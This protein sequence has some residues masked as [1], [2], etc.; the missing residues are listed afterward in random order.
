[1]TLLTGWPTLTDDSGDGTSGTVL[2][3]TVFD[4]IKAQIEDH[5]HTTN[6]T[7]VKPKAITDEVVTARGN[8]TSLE[9]RLDG[10]IDADGDLITP[11]QS[12]LLLSWA[13]TPP[14]IC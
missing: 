5:V 9:D 6:N 2:D 14:S 7:T 3:K 1:M 10:V 4:T 13:H 12:C 11:A 8:R